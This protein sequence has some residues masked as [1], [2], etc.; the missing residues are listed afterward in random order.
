MPAHSARLDGELHDQWPVNHM[1]LAK[2]EDDEDPGYTAVTDEMNRW[3]KKW[4]E[5]SILVQETSIGGR[6]GF[7][8]SPEASATGS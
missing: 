1:D 8:E 5:R 3:I 4:K 6:G 7:V 2:F